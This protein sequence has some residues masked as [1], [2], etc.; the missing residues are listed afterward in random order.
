MNQL[1]DDIEIK[2]SGSELMFSINDWVTQQTVIRESSGGAGMSY[3][4]NLSPDEVIQGIFSLRYSVLF[5]KCII[6]VRILKFT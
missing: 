6:Y 4:Q 3:I 1:A 5:S 2:S